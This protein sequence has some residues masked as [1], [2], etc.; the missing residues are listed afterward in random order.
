MNTIHNI[1]GKFY[2]LAEHDTLRFDPEKST[3]KDATGQSLKV[4]TKV[5]WGTS[6]RGG[7]GAVIGE[8]ADI[9]WSLQDYTAYE[10]VGADNP[11]YVTEDYEEPVTKWVAGRYVP[12]GEMRT[13]K[14]Y[15]SV[16]RQR[17][18]FNIATKALSPGRKGNSFSDPHDVVAIANQGFGG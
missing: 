15:I 10:A 16:T 12:T 11:A 13:R 6:Y 17:W 8:I 18:V 1:D 4:G 5:A 3:V 2:R 9:G 7:G 14:R